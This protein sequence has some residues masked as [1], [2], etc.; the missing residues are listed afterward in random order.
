MIFKNSILF[1]IIAI[2]VLG[3]QSNGKRNDIADSP[4]ASSEIGKESD[5]KNETE[6]IKNNRFLSK[7]FLA[8]A[9]MW[10]VV[11]FAGVG[12]Q[13]HIDPVPEG[14]YRSEAEIE[15]HAAKSLGKVIE[16][17]EETVSAF[18]SADL[19][20]AFYYDSV[21][22]LFFGYKVPLSL[23]PPIL[24][25]NLYHKEFPESINFILDNEGAAYLDIDTGYF[26]KLKLVNR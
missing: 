21:E 13:S 2:L 18:Y 1:L 5:T 4:N 7:E 12:I 6:S 24:Y 3:F 19:P 9:G 15:E 25:I 17:A 23:E 11:S 26:Y 22:D 10:E 16:I 20:N 14:Y 8:I